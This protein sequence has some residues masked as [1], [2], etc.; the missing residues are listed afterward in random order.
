MTDTRQINAEGLQLIKDSEGL[1]L[2][3]YKCPAGVPT[4]GYGTTSNVKMGMTISKDQAEQFLKRDLESFEKSVSSLVKVKLTDNQFSALVSFTYN[5]GAESLAQST[6]LRLL[7]SGDYPGAADQF[8]RW[9][10]GGGQV[11]PGLVKRRA[12]ERSL[13]LKK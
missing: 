8:P 5:L 11:L 1:E 2:S 4:I 9:N 13:F 10:R 12:L 3:A 7:N 6:L